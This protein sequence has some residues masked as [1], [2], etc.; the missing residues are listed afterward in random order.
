[1]Q[2]KNEDI[3]AFL[4]TYE[5]ATNTNSSDDIAPLYAD[6]FMFGGKQGVQSIKKT[7]F[8]QVLPKRRGF[9]SMVGLK[10]TTLQASETVPIDDEY[11]MVK[12]KWS[13]H[14]E[15]EGKKPIDDETLA[16]YILHSQNTTLQIV[17]QIDH[18]DLMARVKELGLM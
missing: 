14:Y 6:T 15:K 12:V 5:Q 9:F 4:K 17:M 1:M 13:I 11:V 2:Q 18:Q 3:Q 7:D 10:T 16:T 8:L